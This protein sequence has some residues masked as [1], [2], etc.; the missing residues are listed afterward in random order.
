MTKHS[1]CMRPIFLNTVS[2]TSLKKRFIRDATR[3][4]GAG[5]WLRVALTALPPEPLTPSDIVTC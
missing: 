1:A 5:T 4:V 2:L 3:L